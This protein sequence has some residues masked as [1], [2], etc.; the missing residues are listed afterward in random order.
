MIGFEFNF[1]FNKKFRNLLRTFSQPF[2]SLKALIDTYYW[3]WPVLLNTLYGL[4]LCTSM[5]PPSAL[6]SSCGLWKHSFLSGVRGSFTLL[7]LCSIVISVWLWSF[8][9]YSTCSLKASN[10]GILNFWILSFWLFEFLAF[11]ISGLWYLKVVI[12]KCTCFIW[13]RNSKSRN[14]KSLKFKIQ[15]FQKPEIAKSR[16]S[17]SQKFKIKKR[18][19]S[20]CKMF[21]V[22]ILGYQKSWSWGWQYCWDIL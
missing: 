12:S 4:Q 2:L 5:V 18:P 11:W 22:E 15:I 21:W 17:K 20:L 3:T 7:L 14:S 6:Q 9:Q 13:A 16:N 1:L 8:L 19:I 10:S